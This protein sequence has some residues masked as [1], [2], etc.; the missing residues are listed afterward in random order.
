[1]T[2]ISIADVVVGILLT[3]ALWLSQCFAL[4]YWIVRRP[5]RRWV[6]VATCLIQ[7]LANWILFSVLD[8]AIAAQAGVP[9]GPAPRFGNGWLWVWVSYYILTRPKRSKALATQM[10]ASAGPLP[11]K[12]P[13]TLEGPGYRYEVGRVANLSAANPSPARTDPTPAEPT[14]AKVRQEILVSGGILED[15]PYDVAGR[16][17]LTGPKHPGTWARAL[18]EA[19]GDPART[20]LAYLK[21]RVAALETEN[22]SRVAALEAEK[23]AR[24]S[25]GSAGE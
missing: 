3:A 12:G 13:T 14:S 22:A 21:L 7:F 2:E 11:P 18:V 6:A 1:L 8:V 24:R 19:D 10:P 4:R 16:E 15:D 23:A 5:L 9:A 25:A 20:E 17:L